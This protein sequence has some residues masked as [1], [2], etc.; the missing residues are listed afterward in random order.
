[1]KTFNK[2]L[3]M[4]T[5]LTMILCGLAACDDGSQS[6]GTEPRSSTYTVRCVDE[7]GAPVSGVLVLFTDVAGETE[8]AI[9]NQTG[10]LTAESEA[11]M[12]TVT[13]S[14]MPNGYTCADPVRSFDD[15][16]DLTLVFSA[17]AGSD[18]TITYTVT[19]VDGDGQP[20]GGVELQFCDES[21]CRQPVVTDDNGVVSE[22]YIES[23]YHVTVNSV[24]D[25]Y[26]AAET[27]YYFNEGE[28]EMTI[29]LITE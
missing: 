3:S 15:S 16:N 10:V 7:N 20:V 21:S 1:M 2:I 6:T 18:D 4:I 8:L 13:V 9:T 11:G 26:S 27:V 19:V 12:R 25:G 28:T 29:V 23:A 22:K 14:T 17:V 5:A 24:P